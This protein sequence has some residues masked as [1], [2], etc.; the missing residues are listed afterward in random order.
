[1]HTG[2][3]LFMA[4]RTL[5][6]LLF[7]YRENCTHNKL[8]T[9]SPL[10]NR[11]IRLRE[12]SGR[13]LDSRIPETRQQSPLTF[14]FPFGTSSIAISVL[15]MLNNS[16][17][18]LP[19]LDMPKPR[20]TREFDFSTP[21]HFIGISDF[22]VLRIL[23]HMFRDFSLRNPDTV[24]HLSTCRLL[25]PHTVPLAIG[26]SCITISRFPLQCSRDFNL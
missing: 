26:I 14:S 13:A 9:G 25:W 20:R 18:Q 7:P 10:Y 8:S 11:E 6:V 21:C 22:A 23:M 12:V 4:Q 5:N 2:S 24:C 17:P 15:T 1:V 19:N 16:I 3:F